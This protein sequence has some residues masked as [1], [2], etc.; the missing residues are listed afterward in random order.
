[1]GLEKAWNNVIAVVVQPGVEFG[2]ESIHEYDRVAARDL[3]NALGK[4]PNLVFE[5]HSTDYQTR[6]KLRRWWRME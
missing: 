6:E 3:S 4:Y 2:D 1:M 5:G